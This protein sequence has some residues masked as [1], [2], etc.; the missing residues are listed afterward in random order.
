MNT[1]SAGGQAVRKEKDMTTY[2]K[3]YG[4]TASITDH[5]DGTATLKTSCGRKR[6][7]KKYKNRKSAYSAWK[8]MCS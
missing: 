8:R 4:V 3:D 1:P 2:Y 5:R 7:S 6:V